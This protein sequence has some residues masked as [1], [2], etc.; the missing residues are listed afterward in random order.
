MLILI[1][2]M[3]VIIIKQSGVFGLLPDEVTNISN[4]NWS[5]GF[6]RKYFDPEK[7][8]ADTVFID[9]SVLLNFSLNVS[10]DAD[11]IV[12]YLT[13]KFKELNLEVAK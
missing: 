9:C 13:E 11:A 5:A 10:P 12:A 2:Q 7:G 1:A 3:I 4:I 6:F 8:K